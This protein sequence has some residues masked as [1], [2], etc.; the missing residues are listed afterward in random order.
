MLCQVSKFLAG[1]CSERS[2]TWRTGLVLHG[3]TP[4][5]WN[6]HQCL[7]ISQDEK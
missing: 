3:K 7:D 5:A 6:V 1:I 2:T 4:P